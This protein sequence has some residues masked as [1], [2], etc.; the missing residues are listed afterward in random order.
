MRSCFAK[1]KE[2]NGGN[3]STFYMHGTNQEH[4]D[5]TFGNYCVQWDPIEGGWGHTVFTLYLH[6]KPPFPSSFSSL[7]SFT[8][9]QTLKSQPSFV[10]VPNFLL[11]SGKAL[12]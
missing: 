12:E 6:L 8:E 11:F 10:R 4:S 1:M 5:S 9:S 2:S 7:F 3:G